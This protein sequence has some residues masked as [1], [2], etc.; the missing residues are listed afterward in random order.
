M[1]SVKMEARSNILSPRQFTDT[2]F[3]GNF[4]SGCCT[5]QNTVLGRFD[6]AASCQ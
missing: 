3:D 1:G 6:P 2:H 4:L 5:D